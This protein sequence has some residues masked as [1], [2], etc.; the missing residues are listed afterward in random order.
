MHKI[1]PSTIK[2]W[3]VQ[4]NNLEDI[5]KKPLS[6]KYIESI[7]NQLGTILRAAVADKRRPVASCRTDPAGRAA[8]G[9][10][11]TPPSRKFAADRSADAKQQAPP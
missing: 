3:L 6:A 8:P 7:A 9:L 2:T 1:T 5:G 10:P 4:L 11:K